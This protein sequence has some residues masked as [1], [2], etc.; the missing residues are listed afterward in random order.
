MESD[1]SSSTSRSSD[2][3]SLRR[4]GPVK[5]HSAR[6]TLI[7]GVLCFCLGGVAGMSGA[8][9]APRDHAPG[10]AICSYMVSEIFRRSPDL[11]A[12][13]DTADTERL[14]RHATTMLTLWRL[15][16]GD[17]AEAAAIVGF[18]FAQ[19][20][21]DD[22]GRPTPGGTNRALAWMV[23]T[24]LEE[25]ASAGR[26]R[27]KVMVQW[28]I[29]QVLWE[30]HGIRAD[31]SATVDAEGNYLS[32]YGVMEQ[33]AVA[34][35]AAGIRTVALVAHPDHGVRC[36]KVVQHFNVTAL[37]TPLLRGEGVPWERFGCD[38][39]GYDAQS[40]QPWTTTRSRYLLHELK[41]RPAMVIAG[42]VDFSSDDFGA[43]DAL[44]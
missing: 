28:E 37:G 21:A 6:T 4:G 13:T 31:V 22:K 7:V 25:Y 15:P 12:L 44:T 3:V 40:T 43:R 42:Q 9:Y 19:G 27:P 39:D 11:A 30:E 2:R 1:S 34:L 23:A 35:D 41:N 33:L 20:P 26:P 14:F 10:C 5:S 18:S 17:L 16:D 29:A 38:A 24:M 8:R 36:G 32:T